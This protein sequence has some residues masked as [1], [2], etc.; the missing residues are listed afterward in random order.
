[1]FGIQTG[2]AI[3]F[4]VKT[5]SNQ[6]KPHDCRIE[7]FALEDEMKKEEKLQ[8]IAE[9]ELAKIDFTSV[10]PDEKHNWLDI[11]DNDWA[12]LLS[13]FN[14][15]SKKGLS[16]ETLFQ[17]YSTGVLSGRDEWV[18]SYD[19]DTLSR[20]MNYYIDEYEKYSINSSD[21]KTNIKWSRNLKR[22]LEKKIF[23]PYTDNNIQK[24]SYRPFCDFYSYDSKLFIDERGSYDQFNSNNN[25]FVNFRFGPRLAF[26]ILATN[27]VPSYSFYSLDPSQY[28]GNKVIG[29]NDKIV[30]NITPWAIE[31]FTTK[32]Q[33][34]TINDQAIFHY[35]YA[36]VHHPAYRKK[37]EINLKRE[38]PRIPL[39]DDFWQWAKWGEELMNLHLNYETIEPWGLIRKD[40]DQKEQPKAKLKAEKTTGVITLD[41]NTE[42]HGIPALAWTYKLGNR[43]ALEWILDQ[44]KEKKPSDPTIAEKFN[45]YRFA[46]YKDK[47]IDLL[48]RVCRVSVVTME[49][50]GKMPESSP[51]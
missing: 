3:L 22:R 7:Y 32:Y 11:S 15:Q 18:V 10:V 37:Y 42:L 48:A 12:S 33:D 2:V 6:L 28:F 29:Q 13:I 40:I 27:H 8:W 41:E 36:V 25:I 38:F 20:K 19:I 50:I 30:S 21:Y 35:V 14:K 5:S 49:I 16:D 46:D 34:E 4:L 24:I 47:V 51:E 39:Y 31:Q 43:S 1:V 9:N 45:T 17:K 44:Y 26:T 23:E